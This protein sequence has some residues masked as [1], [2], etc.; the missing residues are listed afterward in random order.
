MEKCQAE[1][2]NEVELRTAAQSHVRSLQKSMMEMESGTSN[3]KQRLVDV[4]TQKTELQKSYEKRLQ[5]KT[6]SAESQIAQFRR[7]NQIQ[8]ESIQSLHQVKESVRF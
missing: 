3:V 6:Q 8:Q 7:Q 4:E 1:L 2:R 5:E